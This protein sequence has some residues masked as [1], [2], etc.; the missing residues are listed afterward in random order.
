MIRSTENLRLGE[1]ISRRNPFVVPKYQRAYAWDEDEVKDFVSDIQTLY[2]ARSENPDKPRSHFIGGVVTVDNPAPNTYS[3]RRYDIVDGQQRLATFL[4]TISLLVHAI[5]DLAQ[6]AETDGDDAVAEKASS[7]ADTIKADFIFYSEVIDGKIK[8]MVRLKLSKADEFFFEQLVRDPKQLPT[9]TRDSHK[10]LQRALEKIHS[11]L[12]L[13]PIL[14]DPT[15]TNEQKLDHLLL[16]YSSLTQDCY[17]ILIVSDNLAEAYRLFAI[18]NDRGKTLSDGDLLRSTT[19][20]MV[21]GYPTQQ[22]KIES[23][24]DEILANR[25]SQ[26]EDYLR[27]Y[28]PS[29]LGDRAPSRDLADSYRGKFFRQPFPI[30]TVSA[31]AITTRIIGMQEESRNYFTIADGKWPYQ[32]PKVKR[33][34]IYRLDRLIKVLKHTICLPLLLSASRHL[35][36]SQF[37]EIVHMLELFAFRYITIVGAHAGSL[38]TLYNKQ[39]VLIR[40]QGAAYSVQDLRTELQNLQAARASDAAFELGLDEQLIY[41]DRNTAIK[42]IIRHFVT[43]VDDYLPWFRNG[44]L[45]DP[46][47]DKSH[48]FD[49]TLA[50]IEHI[51]PQNPPLP[52]RDSQ[53]EPHTHKL[54]NLSIWAPDENQHA[55]NQPFVAKKPL[56]D[57]SIVRLNKELASLPTWDASELEKRRIMLIDIAKKVF[58]V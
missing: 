27:T 1:L 54:G 32:E 24:W 17:L 3:G 19:L 31:D 40:T 46:H 45:G 22:E 42:Q 58:R 6:Q 39:A 13:T 35:S 11:E 23:C 43:T 12:M 10:K 20:E 16:L 38:S 56:Y 8:P 14:A 18:L 52:Q 15:K 28:Y 26:I 47:P 44:A 2:Q 4:M 51:Y 50:T 48:D 33:W 34:D 29:H 53:L 21:E 37:S 49:L 57:R 9:P 30:T 55:G 5:E 41:N 36:E 25:D 7:Y